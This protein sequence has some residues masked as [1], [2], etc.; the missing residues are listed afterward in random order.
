MRTISIPALLLA[1][2]SVVSAPLLL[3]SCQTQA[4][5]IATDLSPLEFFQKAQEASDSGNYRLA[6]EYYTAFR[7]K[8]PEHVDRNLWASYEIAFLYHKL[9]DDETALDLFSKLI[10]RYAQAD[11]NQLPQ[12]PLI[13][14]EKVRDAIEDHTS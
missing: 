11:A 14:S 2:T 7:Q 6:I 3:V 4:D 5:A 8:Y 12:G 13:L 10:D 9:G 1:V